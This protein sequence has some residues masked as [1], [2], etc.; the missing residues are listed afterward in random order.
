MLFERG[1]VAYGSESPLEEYCHR[2]IENCDILVSI[3]GGK[4][5]TNS[6][7][8][9]YSISQAELNTA[10]E[11]GKQVYIFIERDVYNEYRTYSHNRE[12]QVNLQSVNDKR[13]FEYIT[14]IYDLPYS[15]AVMAFDIA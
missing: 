3:I 6:T 1:Q 10:T 4:I 8:G 14:E 9:H 15:N 5:G 11:S 2:E 13:I 7:R 12:A